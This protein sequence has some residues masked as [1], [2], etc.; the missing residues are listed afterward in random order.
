MIALSMDDRI[1]FHL[2]SRMATV[3]AIN[4]FYYQMN[5]LHLRC[6]RQDDDA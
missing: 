3:D 6:V 1:S 4:S 2:L 5:L